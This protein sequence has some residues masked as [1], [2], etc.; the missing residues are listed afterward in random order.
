[1]NPYVDSIMMISSIKGQLLLQIERHDEGGCNVV[2][3]GVEVSPRRYCVFDWELL[4]VM[5]RREV[6]LALESSLAC[7]G[8][9]SEDHVI[10]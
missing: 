2:T 6:L 3:E 1:V 5:Y 10:E 8:E 4:E 7:R 9:D